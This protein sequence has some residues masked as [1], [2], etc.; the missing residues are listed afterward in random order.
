[1][2][3][4]LKKS[5]RQSIFILTILLGVL[6]VFAFTATVKT[7]ECPA[8]EAGDLFKVP[9]NSAVYLL[10]ADRQRMYFPHAS[11]YKTW[12]SDFSAVIEILNTCVDNYPTPSAPPYGVNY[13]PGSKLIKVQISP[14]VYVV[15]PGNKKSKLGS[16]GVAKSLYG[17][18]WAGK[19]MDVADVF[20]PNYAATGS[21]V[22]EAVPHN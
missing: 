10:N 11:V 20:W 14:S 18:N 21:E 8:L 22:T 1:M 9:D 4:I 7:A 15:E 19:V 12:Y 6:A 5:F 16:E 2:F 13:R 3:H 17:D